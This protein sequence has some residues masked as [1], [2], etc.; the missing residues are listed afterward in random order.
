[1]IDYISFDFPIYL[2]ISKIV[3]N[4]AKKYR[5]SEKAYSIITQLSKLQFVLTSSSPE[6]SFFF[7]RA[8]RRISDSFKDPQIFVPNYMKRIDRKHQTHQ[9]LQK[10]SSQC[11]GKNSV[12]I[13]QSRKFSALSMHAL[14]K[15]E[16]VIMQSILYSECTYW[17]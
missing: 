17:S 8:L 7:F 11:T 3:I 5:N 1:M 12:R 10:R 9:L 2:S 13:V 14:I 6:Y 15:P 16:R 4:S